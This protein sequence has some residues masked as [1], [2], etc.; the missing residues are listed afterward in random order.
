MIQF[1]YVYTQ[2]TYVLPITYTQTYSI[3]TALYANTTN[4]PM[5]GQLSILNKTL[6][7]FTNGTSGSVPITFISVGF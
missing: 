3:A 4:I 2:Q 5:W 6:T 1:G 7:S